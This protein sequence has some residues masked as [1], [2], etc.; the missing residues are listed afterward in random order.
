MPRP[1]QQQHW[2][3]DWCLGTG[4]KM[5]AILYSSLILPPPI[6]TPTVCASGSCLLLDRF[7]LNICPSIE[8][9]DGMGYGMSNECMFVHY[10]TTLST[11]I[12]THLMMMMMMV[13]VVL[14]HSSRGQT[15]WKLY[16]TS[17]NQS[18][19]PNQ[20]QQTQ[21]SIRMNDQAVMGLCNKFPVDSIIIKFSWR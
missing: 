3:V 21:H 10:K 15:P 2:M 13:I 12:V 9:L 11:S 8:F 7:D 14:L 20:T 18:H 1:D 17:L 5:R 19:W 4:Y 6:T 16:W